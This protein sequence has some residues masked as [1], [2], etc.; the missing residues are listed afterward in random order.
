MCGRVFIRA[1]LDELVRAV[2]M[3]HAAAGPKADLFQPTYN[4]APGTW[5]PIITRATGNTTGGVVMAKWGILSQWAFDKGVK[6]QINARS[7]TIR[8]KATFR[9][10]YRRRRTD[11]DRRIF[12]VD[13]DRDRRWQAVEAALCDRDEGRRT[14]QRPQ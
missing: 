13:S 2:G 7:E 1:T 3:N 11:A 5:Y 9:N 4:G 6:P 12:R 14:R 8:E 10:A